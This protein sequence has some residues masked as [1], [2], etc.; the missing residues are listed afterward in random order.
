MAKKTMEASLQKFAKRLRAKVT[1]K[2]EKK[3]IVTVRPR[4]G[5]E[6]AIRGAKF[7]KPGPDESVLRE[8]LR[9][10]RFRKK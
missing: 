3:V 2:P 9:L 4:Q 10:N 1:V 7:V 6:D 8:K 5:D